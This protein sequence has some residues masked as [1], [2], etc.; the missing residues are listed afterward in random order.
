MLFNATTFRT[1]SNPRH[2]KRSVLLGLKSLW[3][4][5]LRSLLT[6]LGIVFGVSSVIAMLSIGEGASYEAQLQIKQLGSQNVIIRSVKP[7]ETNAATETETTYIAEYGLTVSDLNQ[8][9]DTVPGIS[10]V[11]PA[12]S[13]R[14]FV[15]HYARN[16]EC[17][18]MGT[19]PWFPEMRN[20]P[21]TAGR[22]FSDIEMRNRVNVCVLS[23]SAAQELF[24][25]ESPVGKTVRLE[26]TYLR[27]IG[28][29][30]D[31][32]QLDADSNIGNSS[33]T[34][35]TADQ[36][37]NHQLLMP[38]STMLERFGD[39]IFQ[40]SAGGY[41]WEKVELHEV[42]V[43]CDDPDAVVANANAIRH[44]LESNHKEPDYEII[45][46]IE[47]LRQAERTKQ[48]FNIVLGS[49]AAI[50]LIV[51]GIGIM[52][53]MLANVTERTR[54]IGVRRALGAKRADIIFQFLVETVILSGAGGI[55]G[56]ALGL[57]IPFL[58]SQVAGMTTI[59]GIGAPI[60]AFTISV[61][62]GI[63]FGIYPAKRAADLN[64]V[65]AL[66]HE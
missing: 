42:V 53:I 3:M 65:E 32:P 6:A 38:L 36:D 1:L 52:N 63:I 58:V 60:L 30:S 25:L 47:L 34:T 43:K 48:I 33:S 28:I 18:I 62:T 20:L 5:K 59:V 4:R 27:V 2:L 45:V 7:P 41:S 15:W 9:R 57:A 10:I 29:T 64:P 26:G 46:P 40:R 37:Q 19:V 51:G 11:V 56:V 31:S 49:I 61:L 8:I 54:E 35:D 55:I 16:A 14:N 44:I 21:L 12:R 13:I 50:S 17:D 23:D 39:I 24:P 22:F 66:R